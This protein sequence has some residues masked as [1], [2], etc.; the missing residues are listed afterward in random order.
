ME[1][2][3]WEE[4]PVEEV[5]PTNG[6]LYDSPHRATRE[7]VNLADLPLT[8]EHDTEIPV[9]NV[10]G[11]RLRRYSP[12]CDPDAKPCPILVDLHGIRDFFEDPLI[13]NFDPAFEEDPA[14]RVTINAFRQCGFK[15]AGHIQ[16]TKV[17]LRMTEL[18][19]RMNTRLAE[20]IV[21]GDGDEENNDDPP[22]IARAIR[23]VDCQ[24]Y[25]AVMHRVRGTANTHDAQRGD[26]TA[27]LAGSYSQGASQKRTAARL[28]NACNIRLPHTN[29][30]HL[31]DHGELDTSIRVECVF[32]IEIA[33]LKTG[34]QNGR[35]VRRSLTLL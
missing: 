13:T 14:P 27:A 32:N 35:C 31:I 23:G 15:S 21:P 19:D 17:P 24:M 29:F 5:N 25:N 34:C 30:N 20:V 9:Y 22:L 12:L 7:R 10:R 16:V 18:I 28:K 1:V 26:I 8:D 33:K 11:L 3:E 6:Q 4:I 2:E